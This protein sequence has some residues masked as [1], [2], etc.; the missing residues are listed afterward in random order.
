[1]ANVVKF[2]TGLSTSFANLETKDNDTLYFLSDTKQ[3]YKGAD[4]F[5]QSYRT[6]LTKPSTAGI[7]G[8]LYV[9]KNDNKMYIYDAAA[10]TYVEVFDA[11][12]PAPVAEIGETT[13][14]TDYVST[15]A[16]TTYVAAK[17]A[18]VT[19]GSTDAFVTKIENKENGDIGELVVFNGTK[20]TP[21][22]VKMT[23]VALKPSY[24]AETRK[25]TM[26]VQGDE[27]VVIELGKEMVVSSGSYNAETQDIELVLSSG[28]TVKVPVGDLVDTYT[29]G[30]AT[31]S[32]ITVD[33]SEGN[34]ITATLSLDSDS[35]KVENGTLKADFST[36]ALKSELESLEAAITGENGVEKKME[37]LEST[38]GSRMDDIEGD[39][40]SISGV[41]SG[42]ED[43][44]AKKSDLTGYVSTTQQATDLQTLETKIMNNITLSWQPISE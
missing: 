19:G 31:D 8:V 12:I 36:L 26:P 44:Y 38:L 18:E 2:A 43:T 27:D 37:T 20:E 5:I 22:T 41:I 40:E 7:E 30:T 17:I 29:G 3:I 25:I 33:V 35:L 42:L 21:L 24:D 11:A 39:I 6:V 1:M 32:A 4:L 23:G 14:A 13:S 10:A 15:S 9:A 28:E 16:V 34:V